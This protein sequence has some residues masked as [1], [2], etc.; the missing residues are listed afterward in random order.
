M[1]GTYISSTIFAGGAGAIKKCRSVFT[2]QV[3]L[4][5]ISVMNKLASDSW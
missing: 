2:M 1:D 5:I 3:M 4:E